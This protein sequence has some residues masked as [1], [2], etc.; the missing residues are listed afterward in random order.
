MREPEVPREAQQPVTF[1]GGNVVVPHGTVAHGQWRLALV[2]DLSPAWESLTNE[3]WRTVARF[4]GEARRRD[5]CAGRYAA[6]QAAIQLLGA[7]AGHRL[8]I[9]R[10]AGGAPRARLRVGRGREVAVPIR[11][12]VAHRDGRG[13]AAASTLKLHVGVDLERDN[14]I[15][16]ERAR[17]FLTPDERARTS[18]TLEELWAVKEAVWKALACHDASPFTEMELRFD[19]AQRVRAVA[20]GGREEAVDVVLGRPWPG[21][22]LAVCLLPE[23]QT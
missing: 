12:S 23:R 1:A 3:E 20:I 14:G 9:I 7:S 4:A 6:K 22:V 2:S 5:W 17:Y 11:L 8:R 13:V 15:A 16:P 21:Y 10:D 18:R 19:D